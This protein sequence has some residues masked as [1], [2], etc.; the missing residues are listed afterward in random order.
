MLKLTDQYDRQARLYPA[1]LAGATLV[2]IA[3]GVY[4]LPLE[5][6]AGLIGLLA[7]CGV[8]FRL[9]T[10]ARELG[11]RL[12]DELFAHGVANRPLSFCVIETLLSTA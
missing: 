3:V 10:I 11:K 12:E 8:V 4:G 9:T 1:L 2:T 7:S 5:P 6:K